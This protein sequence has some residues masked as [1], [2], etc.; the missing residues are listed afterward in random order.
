MKSDNKILVGFLLIIILSFTQIVINYKLQNDIL[1]NTKQIKDVESPLTLLIQQGISYGSI[2]TEQIHI[3]L[4]HAQIGEYNQIIEHKMVYYAVENKLDNIFNKDSITLLSKSNRPQEVKDN[5]KTKFK[6]INQLN[7]LLADLGNRTFAAIDKKDIETAYSLS[8]SGDYEK[9]QEELQIVVKDLS[10]AVN[11]GFLNIE[12][13]ILKSSQQIV[14]MN[15]IFSLIMFI[16]I[17]ITLFEI[18]SFVVTKYNLYK[19]LYDT[20]NDTIMTLEP[21]DW[22]FTAGNPATI[23]LFNLKNEK[24]LISLNPGDLS[25]EKQPDGQ[26]SSVKSKKMIEKAMKE[27]SAFFTWTHK[28]Y[29]GKDFTAN[30]LLSRV[31][32]DG[33]IYLQATVRKA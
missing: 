27:G 11:E 13:N 19:L 17:I 18:R 7:I 1:D 21:P 12:N 31:K 2:A 14:I 33:K 20:S 4:L 8:V 10:D 25:P 9:Y 15:I 6:E 32:E 22:N 5:I 23:K 26:L 29:I 24:Q 3:S 30:V 16:I 28:Q